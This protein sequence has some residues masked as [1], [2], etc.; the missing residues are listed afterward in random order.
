MATWATPSPNGAC[1][2]AGQAPDPMNPEQ[3]ITVVPEL[4]TGVM[5]VFEIKSKDSAQR[6]LTEL[7]TATSDDS[8]TS[9]NLI[10]PC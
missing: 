8:I 7:V 10:A 5:E 3:K 4:T 2:F 6:K 9:D 1:V